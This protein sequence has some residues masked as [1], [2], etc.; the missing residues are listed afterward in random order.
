LVEGQ[1]YTV[2]AA[3]M[4]PDEI[5]IPCEGVLL[6]EVS[7]A[8]GFGYYADRF[9]PL[10]DISIFTRMLGARA[11]AGRRLGRGA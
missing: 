1:V 7:P 6:E 3:D 10:V 4:V 9:R 11:R 5:G 8:P 2:L